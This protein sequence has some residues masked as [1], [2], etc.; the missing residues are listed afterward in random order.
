MKRIALVVLALSASAAQSS[1]QFIDK[2]EYQNPNLCTYELRLQYPNS[3]PISVEVRLPANS[4]ERD[5]K[6]RAGRSWTAQVT[7]WKQGIC[8]VDKTPGGA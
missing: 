7:S 2:S 6:K 4:T 1:V 3:L 8:G 5:V